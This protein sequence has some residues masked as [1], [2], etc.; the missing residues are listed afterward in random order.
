MPIRTIRFVRY[1]LM[2]IILALVTALALGYGTRS[3]EAYCPFG[4]AESLW[5]LVTAGEF[6]CALGPLNLSLM[7]AIIG[8]VIISKKT[9]C[10]WA[11]PI[12]FL[13]ELSARLSGF[14][15]KRRPKVPER[16]NVLAKLLRY[17][18]LV[19]AL[20][21]TYKTGELVLRGYDPF[22]LI[23]SGIGHGSVGA[24]SIAVLV[25]LV[26]GALVVPMFFCRYLCPLTAVFDPFSRFGLIKIVRNES[27]CTS[28]GKCSL[29]C[30]H[31]IPVQR[32]PVVRQRDCTN[33][34]ECVVSC[35]EKGVLELRAK[36]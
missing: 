30:P 1:G 15:W 27:T 3:F 5:G 11:C 20:Y 13:G 19:V 25:F 36:L 18:V 31:D 9:F 8:L 17:V 22:Y 2:T 34:L 12:G 28:C 29:A 26:A 14:L 32:L 7:L 24:I 6:S 4:G 23:F 10:G 21:F 35:P 33:C 16:A